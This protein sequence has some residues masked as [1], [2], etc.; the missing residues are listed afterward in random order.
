MTIRLLAAYGNYPPNALLTLDAASEAALV[1][2]GEASTNLTGGSV[3]TPNSGGSANSLPFGGAGTG[4]AV[5][6]VNTRTGAIVLTEA[7]VQLS[8]AAAQIATNTSAI[9]AKLTTPTGS[10]TTQVLA[11]D[12]S[13][14]T[15]AKA[16]LQLKACSLTPLK[17]T[18]SPAA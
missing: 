5:S 18:S 9:G 6:S 7:D 15:P 8:G 14:I 11:G 17:A 13:V 1:A 12:G 4:G 3:Y 10:A 2:Q 16:M